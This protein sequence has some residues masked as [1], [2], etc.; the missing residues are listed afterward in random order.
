MLKFSLISRTVWATT[1]EFCMLLFDGKRHL[2][3]LFKVFRSIFEN[4]LLKS[5]EQTDDLLLNLNI[6]YVDRI[7]FTKIVQKV[8]VW[9]HLAMQ[10][11][12]PRTVYIPISWLLCVVHHV[13]CSQVKL[14]IYNVFS[15]SLLPLT[16]QYFVVVSKVHFCWKYTQ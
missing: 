6:L 15:P 7:Y 12:V 16:Y 3:K 2:T 13:L 10:T 5:L 14:S 11:V 9:N 8:F 4:P 1:L